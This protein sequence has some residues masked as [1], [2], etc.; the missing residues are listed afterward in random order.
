MEGTLADLETGARVSTRSRL[1][2]LIDAIAP[3]ARR[4]GCGDELEAARDLAQTNGAMRQRE[5]AR[6]RGLRGLVA[7]L[8][9][10]YL[11]GN[12]EAATWPAAG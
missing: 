12:P 10:E 11:D 7:W 3:T 8:A 1:H 9:D 4:L 6:V 2:E 5:V